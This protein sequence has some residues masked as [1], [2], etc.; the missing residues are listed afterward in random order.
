MTPAL[1]LGAGRGE[2]PVC[3]SSCQAKG[4]CHTAPDT[5]TL[6]FPDSLDLCELDR[7]LEALGTI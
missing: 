2:N 4:F 6:S 1:D 5:N 3:R 7:L